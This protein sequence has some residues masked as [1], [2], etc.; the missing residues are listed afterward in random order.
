MGRGWGVALSLVLMIGGS[1]V[2]HGQTAEDGLDAMRARLAEAPGYTGVFGVARAG[3]TAV[4]T[5]QGRRVGDD[6]RWA[7]VTKMVTAILVLQQVDAGRLSLDAP[8]ATYWPEF[9]VNADRI[10]V[11]QLLTHT[12]GL[13]NPD[14]L[15]DADA[16]G[17][18]DFYQQ[19][20]DWRPVCSAP[21]IAEPGADF[22]YN[23]CDYL[24][25]GEVLERVTGQDYNALVRSR[26]VEPLGL[27]RVAV[28]SGPRSEAQAEGG[29]EPRIDPASWGPA[30]GLYGSASDLLKI[31]RAL[32]EGSLISEASREEMW[33]GDP[34]AGFA[35]LSVWSYSPDLGGCLGQTRLV[36]RYG[37]IGGVQ[38]RNFLLPDEGVA[39]TVY[40][41]D[42]E[43]AFGE[44]WQGQGLSVDLIRAAA[45]GAPGA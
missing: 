40:S 2:A 27:D 3:E 16:D 38:V 15:P 45:C 20:A 9:P 14:A 41:D 31:D 32:M 26:L 11:R 12:S 17:M 19:A 44:V 34:A 18:A 28:P 23:N 33:K 29:P 6:L 13:A 8:L 4:G 42:G 35:A 7:S 21:A 36:E 37:E 22:A 24:V 10:T 30:G 43:T 1:A 5:T 39:L 25:L